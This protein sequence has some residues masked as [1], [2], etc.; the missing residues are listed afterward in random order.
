MPASGWADTTR[1]VSTLWCPGG[2]L[3]VLVCHV[4][5]APTGT[6]LLRGSSEVPGAAVSRGGLTRKVG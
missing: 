2:V 4:P 5:A 6:L 1:V 3:G